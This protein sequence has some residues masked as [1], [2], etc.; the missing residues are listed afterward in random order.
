[1][2][3]EVKREEKGVFWKNKRVCVN[4]CDFG[5][6]GFPMVNLET[7]KKETRY[8]WSYRPHINITISLCEPFFINR[9]KLVG[10]EFLSHYL[11]FK[12][13]KTLNLGGWSNVIRRGYSQCLPVSKQEIKQ[14]IEKALR[15]GR[16]FELGAIF[17]SVCRT[18]DL[19]RIEKFRKDPKTGEIKDRWIVPC[20]DKRLIRSYIIDIDKAEEKAGS[21]WR[22]QGF[23]R[24]K[25]MQMGV[26]F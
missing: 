22:T 7:K 4:V 23:L 25:L 19:L 5:Y 26:E 13:G 1:M 12:L 8:V 20:N 16:Y 18:N 2:S 9:K 21:K 24:K 11:S 15:E 6:V 10:Y 3:I 17:V 14:I